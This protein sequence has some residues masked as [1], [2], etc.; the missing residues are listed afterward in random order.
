MEAYSAERLAVAYMQAPESQ[1]NAM[2]TVVHYELDQARLG[3][4][5]CTQTIGIKHE[6]FHI[7]QHGRA[8]W[9]AQ[10]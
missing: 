10:R 8:P 2:Q 4:E 5:N 9:S 1:A 3:A 6:Q 7:L